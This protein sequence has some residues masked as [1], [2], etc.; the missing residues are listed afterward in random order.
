[1]NTAGR[2]RGFRYDE[3]KHLKTDRVTQLRLARRGAVAYLIARQSPEDEPVIF[4]RI[5]VGEADVP[6]GSFGAAVHTGGSGQETIVRF[7]SL[8]IH[9]AQ[10]K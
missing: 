5:D 7:K 10:F 8:T 4:G 2:D 1:M 3:L 6:L 9:A